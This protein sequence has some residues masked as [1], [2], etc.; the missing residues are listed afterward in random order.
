MLIFQTFLNVF[1]TLT[2]V[3]FRNW[4]KTYLF[5][6]RI[7]QKENQKLEFADNHKSLIW[8]ELVQFSL[9]NT[10]NQINCW[11]YSISTYLKVFIVGKMQT[12]RPSQCQRNIYSQN[13]KVAKANLYLQSCKSK[14]LSY[15]DVMFRKTKL[16]RQQ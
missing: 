10:K 13:F 8:Q 11:F 9:K 3:F 7:F 16:M 6:K 4:L 14:F 12:F 2:T 5:N 1:Y 15:I